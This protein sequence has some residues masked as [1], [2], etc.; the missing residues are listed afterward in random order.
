[1]LAQQTLST[2]STNEKTVFLNVDRISFKRCTHTHSHAHTH[3][4]NGIFFCKYQGSSVKSDKPHFKGLA[5][6]CSI[7]SILFQS[8][9]EIRG[10]GKHLRQT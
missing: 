3:T 2:Y 5:L 7:L 8:V 4:H 1:M 6:K 10:M 9:T